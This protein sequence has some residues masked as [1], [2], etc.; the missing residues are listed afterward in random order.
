[1]VSVGIDADCPEISPSPWP[2]R[3][4]KFM[5]VP[6]VFHLVWTEIQI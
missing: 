3:L 4:A 5:P 2:G 6:V 1:M